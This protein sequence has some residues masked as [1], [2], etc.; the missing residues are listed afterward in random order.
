MEAVIVQLV[1]QGG[2]L[3]LLAALIWYF[4]ARV[5]PDREKRFAEERKQRDE[6]FT[7]AL[8]DITDKHDVSMS[9]QRGQFL[10]SLKRDRR[11]LKRIDANTSRTA[12]LLIATITR[13]AGVRSVDELHPDIQAI[14]R[15]FDADDGR[16]RR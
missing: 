2:A 5:L 16:Q 6:T 15:E 11:M 12:A 1:V 7:K 3:G 8:K 13:Q 14:L 4:L 9:A 10:V